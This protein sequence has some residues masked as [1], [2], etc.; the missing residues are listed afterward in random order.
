MSN[1][2][3]MQASHQIRFLA[4][5]FFFESNSFKG[6]MSGRSMSFFHLAHLWVRVYKQQQQQN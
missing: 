6:K 5:R 2:E 1:N 4:Y 3:T